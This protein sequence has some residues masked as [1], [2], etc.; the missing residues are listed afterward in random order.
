M[1]ATSGSSGIIGLIYVQESLQEL[2]G[3]LLV[4]LLGMEQAKRPDRR[5]A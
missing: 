4:R 5:G 1:K 3:Q 2:I